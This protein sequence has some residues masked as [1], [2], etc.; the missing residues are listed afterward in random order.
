[1]TFVQTHRY[2]MAVVNMF[3]DRSL[4]HAVTFSISPL[5][6][7]T[8]DSKHIY[9]MC[10]IDPWSSTHPSGESCRKKDIPT[11]PETV[12]QNRNDRTTLQFMFRIY[13]VKKNDYEKTEN[14]SVACRSLTCTITIEV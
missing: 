11:Y 1:M 14:G 6:L 10:T 4:D 8:S 12:R 13:D 9:N 3:T 2:R 5:L 7:S